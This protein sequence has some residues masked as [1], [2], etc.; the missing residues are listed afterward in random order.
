MSF[1]FIVNCKAAYLPSLP[2]VPSFLPPGECQNIEDRLGFS[3]QFAK[4]VEEWE[5]GPMNTPMH[6]SIHFSKPNVI[7]WIVLRP[8]D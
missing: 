5:S 4:P 1:F 6:V 7:L 8:T 2:E 3:E